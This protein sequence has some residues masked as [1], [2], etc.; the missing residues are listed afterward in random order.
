MVEKL[1]STTSN[2]RLIGDYY[3]YAG[4]DDSHEANSIE[5]M[6]VSSFHS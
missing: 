3:S 5:A 1:K 2:S 4:A 6:I